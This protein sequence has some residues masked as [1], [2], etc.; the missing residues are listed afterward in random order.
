M[1]SRADFEAEFKKKEA[2]YRTRPKSVKAKHFISTKN[3]A[4]RLYMKDLIKR[5][6]EAKSRISGSESSLIS[7]VDP[8]N[9]FDVSET[10]FLDPQRVIF[11]DSKSVPKNS[12]LVQKTLTKDP[13]D[14]TNTVLVQEMYPDSQNPILKNSVA[15]YSEGPTGLTAHDI[16]YNYGQDEFKAPIPTQNQVKIDLVTA[17]NQYLKRLN[18]GVLSPLELIKRHRFQDVSAFKRRTAQPLPPRTVDSKK[19][20]FLHRQL[21]RAPKHRTV[22]PRQ[23]KTHLSTLRTQNQLPRQPKSKIQ[24]E[25]AQNF[26]TLKTQNFDQT[27]SKMITE[28]HLNHIHN[29]EAYN[30]LI[31]TDE[32]PALWKLFRRYTIGRSQY[33]IMSQ[34]SR[35]IKLK[36]WEIVE[37]I[38]DDLVMEVVEVVLRKEEEDQMDRIQGPQQALVEFL[39]KNLR[40]LGEMQDLVLRPYGEFWE[41]IERVER[42]RIESAK[43]QADLMTRGGLSEVNFRKMR[44][45][46]LEDV[47]G[48]LRRN[49]AN[50]AVVDEGLGALKERV[51]RR[52]RLKQSKTG[53]TILSLPRGFVVDLMLKN[54]LGITED[55]KYHRIDRSEDLDGSG[56]L[57]IVD[58]ETESKEAKKSLSEHLEAIREEKSKQKRVYSEAGEV[59]AE[60]F[61]QELFDEVYGDFEQVRDDLISE[62]VREELNGGKGTIMD[63]MDDFRGVPLFGPLR[64]FRE[65]IE[66]VSGSFKAF[67]N[68]GGLGQGL[69]LNDRNKPNYEEEYGF[70]ALL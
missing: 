29:L 68:L 45:L 54:G 61:V 47:E 63:G 42:V 17:R 39:F 35:K 26:Q 58:L 16:A 13:I 62:V 28:D 24:S 34:I 6:K 70:S 4:H 44:H 1:V 27:A 48:I 20:A 36:N 21:L 64:D 25:I 49:E 50:R 55:G 38:L 31:F 14:P 46:G 56:N 18:Q 9:D 23:L 32:E 41:E 66:T 57:E 67:G 51:R 11:V 10:K 5:Q 59:I 37:L 19:M 40:E 15:V 60:I 3:A 52:M 30:S 8:L 22:N 43:S 12:N 7:S 2:L 69:G 53:I 33:F 65:A